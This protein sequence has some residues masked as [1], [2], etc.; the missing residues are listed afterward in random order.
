M[1]GKGSE[2]LLKAARQAAEVARGEA[3]AGAREYRLMVPPAVDVKAMRQKMALTQEAFS[4]M[5]GF[6]LSTVKKWESG[7]REP[8]RAA[9]ILLRTIE[10]FPEHVIR[11]NE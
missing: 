8:E 9:R 4:Q 3:V 7:A 10:R 11:A 1:A 6:P 2:K 5:F